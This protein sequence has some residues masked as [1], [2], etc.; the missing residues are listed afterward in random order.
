MSVAINGKQVDMAS[1]EIDGIYR[2][3]APEFCEA[4]WSYGQFED[5]TEMTEPELEELYYISPP[6]YEDIIS[7]LY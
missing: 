2:D 1:L 4:H 5:G 6:A 3:D 7:Y